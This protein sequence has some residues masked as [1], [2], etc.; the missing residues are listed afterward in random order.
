MD[1]GFKVYGLKRGERRGGSGR[2]LE[3]RGGQT[4][5]AGVGRGAIADR[6]G[7]ERGERSEER[8]GKAEGEESDEREE[9]LGMHWGCRESDV[10]GGGRG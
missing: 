10:A 6:G 4:L 5:R 3:A 9:S 8:E 1:L 2:G 7:G